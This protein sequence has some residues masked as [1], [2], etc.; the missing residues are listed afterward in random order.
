MTFALRQ[1]FKLPAALKA[2]L[3]GHYGRLSQ[4]QLTPRSNYLNSASFV[5]CTASV[6]LM[7][8]LELHSHKLARFRPPTRENAFQSTYADCAFNQ[9]TVTF[10]LRRLHGDARCNPPPMGSGNEH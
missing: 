7:D 8:V 4:Q 10:G 6:H 2:L 1:S 9:T 5:Q 3:T